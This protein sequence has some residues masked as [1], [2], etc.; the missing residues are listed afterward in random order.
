MRVARL[1]VEI[2]IATEGDEPKRIGKRLSKFEDYCV[3]TGSIREGINVQVSVKDI[4]EKELLYRSEPTA[5][6][7]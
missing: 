1:D 5:E 7:V 3:V 6:L 2:I 4:E